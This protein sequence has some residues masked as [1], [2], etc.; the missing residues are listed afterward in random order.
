M[1]LPT[2]CAAGR[3]GH[4]LIELLT[5][6]VL[7]LV[8]ASLTAPSMSSYIAEARTRRAL[9]RVASDIAYARMVAVRAR[10]PAAITFSSG[11]AY[12]IVLQTSPVKV[13]RSVSL[14][15]E[16]AGVTV[17]PPVT[18]GSLVFDARGLLTTTN[19]GPII[20]RS[21]HSADTAVITPTGRIYRDY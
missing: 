4:S 14:R 17:T 9:D 21:I 18:S 11:T 1:I 6:L 3:D 16:Y 13:I 7:I 8:I 20:T 15:G 2:R 19:Y 10:T 12:T 5:V